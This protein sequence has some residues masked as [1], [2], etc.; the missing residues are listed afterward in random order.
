MADLHSALRTQIVNHA[1]WDGGEVVLVRLQQSKEQIWHTL[2]VR[3]SSFSMSG[4]QMTDLLSIIGFRRS[5]CAFVNGGQCYAREV[6]QSFDVASFASELNPMYQTLLQAQQNLEQCG[7]P[8]DQPEGWAFFNGTSSRATS[9]GHSSSAT[10]ILHRR[11]SEEKILRTQHSSLLSRGLSAIGTRVGQYITLLSIC[12]CLRR[13]NPSLTSFIFSDSSLV[14]SLIL[15]HAT[16]ASSS[17][18][19]V[20]THF[21]DLPSSSIERSK[22][23]RSISLLVW[24]SCYRQIEEPECLVCKFCRPNLETQAWLPYGHYLAALQM[25]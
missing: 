6:S 10:D 2:H 13:L 21:S 5:I 12:P 9:F 8:I 11:S 24:R 14:L 7:L 22:H 4:L 18:K 23:T 15:S 1:G 20:V 16:G 3:P 19:S 17:M 25:R